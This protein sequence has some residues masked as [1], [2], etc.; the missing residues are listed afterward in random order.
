M[1]NTTERFG[2][3]LNFIGNI[4]GDSSTSIEFNFLFGQGFNT[5]DGEFIWGAYNVSFSGTANANG[6]NATG[7][8]DDGPNGYFSTT[9]D[10]NFYGN[11]ISSVGGNINLSDSNGDTIQNGTFS[12]NKQ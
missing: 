6:F 3:P 4:N 7:Q 10:G 9:I 5:V 12:A 1:D 8:R 11:E 2:I